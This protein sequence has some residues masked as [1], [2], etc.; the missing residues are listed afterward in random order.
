MAV[1]YLNPVAESS[2]DEEPYALC[3]GGDGPVN[4]GL[5]AN[6]FPDSVEFLSLVGE[7][8]QKVIGEID[9]H[10]FDKGAAV[11]VA[12]PLADEE[13][14]TITGQVDAVVAAWGH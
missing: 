1:E 12:L 8:M 10:E 3:V 14:A 9:V 5:L 4:V 7:E 11:N 2:V 6:S 13:V